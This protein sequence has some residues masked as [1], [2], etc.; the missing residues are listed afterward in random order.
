MQF[1]SEMN[2]KY[3]FAEGLSYP[4]NVTECR[5]VYVRALNAVA[6]SN[7]SQVRAVAFNRG[8]TRNSVLILMVSLPFFNTLTPGQVN[9]EEDFD[10]KFLPF[11]EP[12]DEAW[13]R[14]VRQCHEMNL[15]DFVVTTTSIEPEFDKY[16]EE[17]KKGNYEFF[18]GSVDV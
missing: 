7:G 5:E 17:F 13:E 1:F 11:D 3:G 4:P 15:D 10:T 16:L 9:G 6:E 2:T 12:T 18:L 8:G 14:T